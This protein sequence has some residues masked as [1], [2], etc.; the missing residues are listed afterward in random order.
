MTETTQANKALGLISAVSAIAL[1]AF[2]V[3]GTVLPETWMRWIDSVPVKALMFALVLIAIAGVA[4]LLKH[5]HWYPDNPKKMIWEMAKPIIAIVFMVGAITPLVAYIRVVVARNKGIE[6]VFSSAD[7][8]LAQGVVVVL[9]I[10][11]LCFLATL[12]AHTHLCERELEN[13]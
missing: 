10:V 7:F 4:V 13:R 2:L 1:A 5:F 8:S 3:W 11:S 6:A 12:H 9:G